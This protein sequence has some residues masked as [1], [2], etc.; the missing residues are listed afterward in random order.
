VSLNHLNPMFVTLPK[1]P[2][3]LQQATAL[4]VPV[5]K[6]GAVPPPP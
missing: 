1:V 6:N 5:S 3:V 4:M 2:V